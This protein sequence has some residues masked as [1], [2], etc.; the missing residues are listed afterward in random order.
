MGQV[1][2]NMDRR[3]ALLTLGIAS[4]TYIISRFQMIDKIL[5]LS[6]TERMP[7]LFIGHGSPMNALET[8][9]YTRSLAQLGQE[10]AKP[11]AIL[12]ISAHWVTEATTVTTMERPKTIH[13][14][15][16]FPKALFDIEYPAPGSPEIAKQIQELA[17]DSKILSDYESWGLDHGTWAVLRH[18]YPHAEIPVLQLSLH[19]KQTVDYHVRLGHEISKLR[20]KGVLILGSGNLVHNLRQIRWEPDAKPYEWAIEFDEWIKA[21]LV[22]GDFQAVLENFHST[23]AGQLSIPTLEHYLPLHY[24]LGASH[25]SDQLKFEFEELQNGSISMRSFSLGRS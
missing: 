9:S 24:I 1:E 19:S 12:V 4:T 13:D 8:N 17:L 7:V 15:Y 10:L 5:S 22:D 11:R 23:K 2:K 3:N 21:K 25:R 18:M 20:D 6:P 16:G 14:F